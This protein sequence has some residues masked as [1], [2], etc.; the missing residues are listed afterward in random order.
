MAVVYE[1]ADA[2]YF[3]GD[4]KVTLYRVDGAGQPLLGAPV[5]FG[6]C[7]EG[8]VL[9]ARHETV[10]LGP[11]GGGRRR[12]VTDTEHGLE[13]RRVWVLTAAGQ[14]VRMNVDGEHVLDVEWR[15][16]SPWDGW[17]HDR[18]HRRRYRGVVVGEE[19]LEMGGAQEL[20]GRVVLT[21]EDYV[22][23]SGQ[24][25]VSAPVV[26]EV[27][28]GYMAFFQ[29]GPMMAPERIGGEYVMQT[30]G[31]LGLALVKARA[32]QGVATVV[33]LTVDGAGTGQ[34]VTLAAG[35]ANAEVSGQVTLNRIVS[36]G[37]RIG[38][39]T[40]SGPTDAAAAAW[41]CAVTMAYS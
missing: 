11:T 14:D 34:V 18:W 39:R 16:D 33:E 8:M 40:A 17:N 19:G 38:W 13:F 28:V 36:A 5:F 26:S 37:Q 21:A 29:E 32:S 12:Y 20:L 41:V 15:M 7:T 23:E 27:G 35:A 9:T 2:L 31:V 3:G 25:G 10:R 24:G 1:P 6:F 30:A 22:A 4:A